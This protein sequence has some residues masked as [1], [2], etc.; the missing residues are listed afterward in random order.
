MQ[1]RENFYRNNITVVFFL[2][3]EIY[4]PYLS[5]YLGSSWTRIGSHI[6]GEIA[7]DISFKISISV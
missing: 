1:I 3:C 4:V 2:I 6:F 7:V 5:F